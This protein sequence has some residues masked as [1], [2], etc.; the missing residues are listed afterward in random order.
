M[1][2]CVRFFRHL[3][4]MVLMDVGLALAYLAYRLD[5]EPAE[6]WFHWLEKYGIYYPEEE[7]RKGEPIVHWKPEA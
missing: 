3:L 4:I 5:R 7:V 2:R 1:K 6:Y